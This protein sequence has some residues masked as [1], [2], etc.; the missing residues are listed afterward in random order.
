MKVY[1]V[2]VIRRY[3]RQTCLV[4]F[5]RSSICPTQELENDWKKDWKMTYIPTLFSHLRHKVYLRRYG[6]PT[7]EV[8]FT[9]SSIYRTQAVQILFCID[10]ARKRSFTEVALHSVLE[11]N[12][13]SAIDFEWE[14]YSPNKNIIYEQCICCVSH[15]FHWRFNPGTL[16][17][18]R[19]AVRSVRKQT[20]VWFL[21]SFTEW[22][23]LTIQTWHIA[24]QTLHQNCSLSVCATNHSN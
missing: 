13:A 2:I 8:I 24:I 14:F 3:G 16:R 23:S 22:G 7:C 6:R 19:S 15:L 12:A 21:N 10:K 11:E 9:H 17:I 20:R 18:A 4:F 5:T 1:L